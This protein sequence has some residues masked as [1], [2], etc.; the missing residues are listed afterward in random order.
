MKVK[1]PE[2]LMSEI[3]RLTN[4]IAAAAQQVY[5]DWDQ[6]DGYSEEYGTGGICDD[7]AAEIVDVLIRAGIDGFTLYNE[8]ETH[9]SAYAYYENPEFNEYEEPNV[10]IR[11]DIHPSYYEDGYGYTWRKIEGVRLTGNIVRIED[12]SDVYDEYVNW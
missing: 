9:T 6:V 3:S 10:L 8:Y 2:D 12:Y 7:V 4:R 1:S 5:D 11:V